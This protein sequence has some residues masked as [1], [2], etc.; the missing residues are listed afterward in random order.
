M[1]V[2]YN[3][4]DTDFYQPDPATDVL[5]RARRRP[6]PART[7]P[8]SAGSPGRRACRTCCGPALAFDPR[9]QIVL[10][11]GAADTPELKAETD[12]LI[13]RAASRA[14]T[15][16][17]VVS[18]MLPRES[19]RQV[20]THALAFLLPVGLRA[21]R[22]RQPRGD[23]LR[24]RRRGER[25]RRHPR[26]GR[27]RRDR[28]AGRVHARRH[29]AASRRRSPRAST[30]WPP[31]RRGPRRWA[32]PAGARAVSTFDWRGD[33]RGDRRALPD[34]CGEPQWPRATSQRPDR[35]GPGDARGGRRTRSARRRCRRT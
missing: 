1:H 21:A 25:R 34:P 29:R 27:R 23:G 4:I 28:A 26:G 18:E 19:V 6:R 5:E 35:G 14:A 2:I 7:S 10:L 9:L 8:S 22:H 15:A 3:G 24:D 13:D 32:R 30:S 31:T 12:A 16:S 33:R 11:A 17:F 20:L